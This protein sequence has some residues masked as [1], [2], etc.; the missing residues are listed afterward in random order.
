MVKVVEFHSVLDYFSDLFFLMYMILKKFCI[1]CCC[2]FS[3]WS[4][5]INIKCT[6]FRLTLFSYTQCEILFKS[7]LSLLSKLVFVKHDWQSWIL[8][9]CMMSVVVEVKVY[10]C[11][12]HVLCILYDWKLN[13]LTL[14][15]ALSKVMF[16][17]CTYSLRSL[18]L[19]N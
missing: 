1:P 14:Y 6:F 19:S 18:R 15:N 2:P 16:H 17:N 10:R 7:T 3:Y 11:T 13:L 8:T 5:Q 4:I 9:V 12:R